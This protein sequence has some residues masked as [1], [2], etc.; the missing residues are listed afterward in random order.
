MKISIIAGSIGLSLLALAGTANALTFNEASGSSFTQVVT[1]TPVTTNSI[2]FSVSGLNTQFDALSFSFVGGPSA[3]GSV[4]N[5]V[6]NAAFN[7]SRNTS[8]SLLAGTPYQVTISGHTLGGIPGG[9][10]TLT[11][12]AMNAVIASVPEPESYAMLLAGLGLLGAIA[13]RRNERTD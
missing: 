3:T 11:V 13:R 4:S 12:T 8:Y 10:A 6:R 5:G 1:V 2:L 9:E 7:D